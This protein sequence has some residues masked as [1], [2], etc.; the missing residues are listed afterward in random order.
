LGSFPANGVSGKVTY[1]KECKI[2][3]QIGNAVEIKVE[4][5]TGSISFFK[6]D[7]TLIKTV[8]DGGSIDL[9]GVSGY[10][11]AIVNG[12]GSPS[13]TSYNADADHYFRYKEGTT[14]KAAFDYDSS[15]DVTKHDISA[16]RLKVP[17]GKNL[18]VEAYY[19]YNPFSFT[20]K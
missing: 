4:F 2:G 16:C 8:L 9:S 1:W 7:G 5:K 17:T 10:V 6:S 18:T 11:Y 20:V 13:H 15:I 3:E 14:Y 12:G 19:A